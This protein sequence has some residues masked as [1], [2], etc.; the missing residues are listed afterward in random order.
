MWDEN[1][2]EFTSAAINL[3][4]TGLE[5]IPD[6]VASGEYRIG[7]ADFN[8]PISGETLQAGTVILTL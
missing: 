5:N 7:W 6:M 2:S 8:P 1:D 4:P 3:L